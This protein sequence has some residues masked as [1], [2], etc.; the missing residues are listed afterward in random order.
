MKKVG[1]IAPVYNEEGIIE[2]L[3]HRVSKSVESLPYNFEFIFVDDGSTDNTLNLLLGIQKKEC[4]LKIIKLSRNWGYQNA[5]NA[6]LDYV[7][8][9]AAILMDGDLEDPPEL[10]KL[11][12]GKWEEGFDIV[13]AVKEKRH[14]T[15]FKRL[16]FSLFYSLM[17]RFSN[18]HIDRQSGT[19]SLLDKKVVSELK[20]FK[21]KYKYYVGLRAFVGFKRTQISYCRERRHAGKPKQTLGR[22]INYGLDALFSFS[23]LPIRL[24]TYFGFFILAIITIFSFLLIYIKMFKVTVNFFYDIPGWTSIILVAFF[25]LGIQIIFLG[26]IGEYI[27]RIFDEVRNRPYYIVESVFEGKGKNDL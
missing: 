5:F 7:D 9:D 1:V 14:E 23:F 8:A 24:L 18:V 17:E 6:G 19:F 3:M 26:V 4:R 13:F 11:F 20:K 2:E 25:I 10:I 16:L 12:L 27:V 15:K 22:L 21:E